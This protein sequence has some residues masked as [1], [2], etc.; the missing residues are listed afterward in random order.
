MPTTADVCGR[1]SAPYGLD[2]R[3]MLIETDE[4]PLAPE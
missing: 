2:L 4:L 1:G 3:C